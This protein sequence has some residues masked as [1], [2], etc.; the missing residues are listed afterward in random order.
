MSGW[1]GRVVL[2]RR[3][4]PGLLILGGALVALA[5]G[6]VVPHL[7]AALLFAGP[8]VALGLVRG[9]ESLIV[10]AWLAAA[11]LVP[12]VQTD[13][14]IAGGLPI[15]LLATSAGLGLMLAAW[16]SR[17]LARCPVHRI[18]SSVPLALAGVLLVYTLARLLTGQPLAFPSLSLPF[19][20]FPLTTLVG[21]LWLSHPEA[22]AG[23][24]RAWPVVAGLLIAWSVMYVLGSATGCGLC[25][26]FVGTGLQTSIAFGGTTR[27]FTSGQNAQIGLLLLGV[28]LL[29]LRFTPARAVLVVVCLVAVGLE[30]SRAQYGG[31]LAGLAVLLV[32]RLGAS[33]PVARVVIGCV[34]ALALIALV[35][36]P[37]GQRGLSAVTEL[38]QNGGNAG[39]RLDLVAEQRPQFSVFGQAVT[40]ASLNGQVNYDLGITNTVVV[41]GWVGAGL[42]L[43]LLLL[44]LLRGLRARTLAGMIVASIMLLVLVSRL[45]LPLLEGSSSAPVYGLAVAFALS[46]PIRRS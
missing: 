39:Y 20:A 37:I 17:E 46:L 7:P 11:G 21:A 4:G 30:S 3:A 41:L 12:F 40:P 42:Q 32:W 15:W 36:S 13:Q 5:A 26:H 23:L 2:H 25:Q 33:G 24:R 10:L 35:S 31:V 44:A 34:V 1:V 28:A 27:L 14:F 22:A 45:T 8:V 6:L 9:V 38:K 18:P 43:A 29:L 19:V 16:G